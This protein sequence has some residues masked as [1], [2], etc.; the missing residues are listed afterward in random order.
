MTQL[1]PSFNAYPQP[2]DPRR[3]LVCH[4]AKQ[5]KDGKDS[6]RSAMAF[7]LERLLHAL[8]ISTSEPLTVRDVQ[9]V[10]SRYHAGSEGAKRD[11]SRSRDA[12]PS[13]ASE[14]ET[15]TRDAEEV[16]SLL[17]AAQVREAIES[18]RQK[19]REAQAVYTIEESAQGY[20]I[21][22]VPEMADWVRLLRDEPR[23]LRLSQAQLEVLTLVAYRQP[24]TRAELEAIR[25]V[26]CD[27]PLNKLM[28]LGLVRNTGRA[29]LPGR[30]WQYGTTARFLEFAGIRGLED[31]PASDV[32]SASELDGW[33]RQA[34]QQS[35]PDDDDVG[36]PPTPP[37]TEQTELFPASD[38]R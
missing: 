13:P 14:T 33:I 5:P 9:K 17:T 11:N 3:I 7:D 36:L 34:T 20:R 15:Q 22:V 32:V 18:L 29:E 16:P 30:P 12:P 21:C 1:R 26:A 38:P 6:P 8:L 19:L 31:L 2:N 27:G 25:G 23:P 35:K 10:I 4:L 37:P 24:V 28:E